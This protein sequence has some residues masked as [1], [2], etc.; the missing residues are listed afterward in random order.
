MPRWAVISNDLI[1]SAE[2]GVDLHGEE[3][4]MG[5]TAT[6]PTGSTPPALRDKS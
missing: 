2:T 5:G 3:L 4:G 1:C 6:T